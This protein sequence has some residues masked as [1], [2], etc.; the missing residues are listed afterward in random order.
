MFCI[1]DCGFFQARLGSHPTAT[2]RGIL[3]AKHLLQLGVR[4]RVG[5]GRSINVRTDPWLPSAGSFKTFTPPI[6]GLNTLKVE[7]LIY[8]DYCGWRNDVINSLF[9]KVDIERILKIPL[10]NL[11]WERRIRDTKKKAPAQRK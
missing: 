7:S 11:C 2:W 10:G 1:P 4:W 9:W 8:P 5:N 3:A 6:S